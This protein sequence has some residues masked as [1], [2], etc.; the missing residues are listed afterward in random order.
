VSLHQA[1]SGIEAEAFLIAGK[2]RSVLAPTQVLAGS[3]G[4]LEAVI[5]EKPGDRF[6]W[7]SVVERKP[8]RSSHFVTS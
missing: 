1:G 8:D 7:V 5:K 2:P 6:K 3:L 4:F